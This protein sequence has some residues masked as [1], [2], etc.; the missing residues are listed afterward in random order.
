MISGKR[1]KQG[2]QKIVSAFEVV[3]VSGLST[4]PG[5]AIELSIIRHLCVELA[6][7]FG[8][9]VLVDVGQME[10]DTQLF[11]RRERRFTN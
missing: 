8:C 11:F 9:V 6:G 10:H 2:H 5:Y 3:T 4:V 1:G 7:N